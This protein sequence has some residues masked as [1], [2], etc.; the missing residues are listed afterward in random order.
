M[1]A[2]K[3]NGYAGTS[4]K[5]VGTIVPIVLLM[6]FIFFTL[7]RNEILALSKD[8]LALE[9]KNYAEHISTWTEQIINEL[10][11]YKCVIEQ[12]GLD[13]EKTFQMMETSAGTH[14]AYPYGL[15]MGD[16]YGN[17]FDSSGWEPDEDFVVTERDWYIEGLEH[18][19]FT[20]GEPY[21]DA[22]T[23]GTCVSVT[24][25]IENYSAV[26]VLS[27]DVYL[28][29]ASQL[30]TEIAEGRIENAFFVAEGSRMILADSDST[31]IGRSLNDQSNSLLYQN[32]NRLLD[33]G[34]T[35]QMEVRGEHGTY[36][37]DINKI[38]NTDWLFVT[39]M[40]HYQMFKTLQRVQ[41]LM[42]IV[43]FV[44]AC[45]LAAVTSRV[46]KEM[47]KIR[48]KAKTDPLTRLLNRDGFKE[49]LLL[50]LETYP[51][52]GI[53]L[54]IDVDNFKLIN[55]QLG[56]PEGDVVLRRFAELLESY[57]NRN[58]DI[59]GR[60]GGDE[61]AVFVGR[62]ITPAEV[63]IMLKKFI[64][65]I[66]ETFDEKYPDQKLSASIGASFVEE[67]NGYEDLYQNADTALY[68][69]KRNGKDG[70][71]IL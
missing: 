61:F 1:K 32:I 62:V 31:M 49:M 45:I 67:C 12:M 11:I 36:F 71:R 16:E 51:D 24:T 22:M 46:A 69:V 66:H 42:S 18:K 30:V 64:I 20:F 25:R 55:D 53:L 4:A 6:I 14:D 50:A 63:E 2:E 5:L 3:K 48:V 7:T 59:V 56:H 44:A 43:A 27:A 21:V 54:I 47:S 37:I 9:S 65:L 60:L 52:Q 34:M 40:S 70:F 35:G 17:Y 8:T 41:V 39:C 19:E 29:Y 58:K 38:E 26:C 57:F 23:G 68:K 13:D 33:Q 28:D 10:D 15:Y